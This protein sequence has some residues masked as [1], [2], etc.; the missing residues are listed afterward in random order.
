MPAS[1]IAAKVA[2]LTQPLA[3]SRGL[4]VFSVEYK[5]GGQ[6]L[7]VFIDRR[8]GSV[9]LEDCQ[10]VSEQLSNKLD[11][12]DL[13]K[14]TYRL[15][16]SSPGL[17][18]PLRN[19]D[20]YNRFSGERAKLALAKP[21]GGMSTVQGRIGECRNGMVRMELDGGESLWVPLGQLR[22]ARLD[23][24]GASGGGRPSGRERKKSK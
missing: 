18:R 3:Q 16:V 10:A 22:W 14:H 24:S 11:E 19:E 1:E 21:L 12:I 6:L 9:G 7:R 4:E 20:D 23:P 13:V 15:E 5:S 8:G 2:E 17:D